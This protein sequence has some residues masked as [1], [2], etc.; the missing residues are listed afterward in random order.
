M[1]NTS[2]LAN[3]FPGTIPPWM[4]PV[5]NHWEPPSTPTVIDAGFSPTGFY[6][7]VQDPTGG[8]YSMGGALSATN[9]GLAGNT[10]YQ[11]LM[12]AS[13]DPTYRASL[14][15][16][17]TTP[18]KLFQAGVLKTDPTK[19]IPFERDITQPNTI[20]S[21]ANAI[22]ELKSRGISVPGYTAALPS[23]NATPVQNQN[24]YNA[25]VPEKDYNP[26]P[27]YNPR[28]PFAR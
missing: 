2:P 16:R 1:P 17:Q 23:Y 7:T 19:G 18:W 12:R 8:A 9:M 10:S 15:Q 5:G 22:A 21:R 13:V 11:D 25:F 3:W 4:L 28:R 6:Q 24:R 14:P 27:A 20:D 26:F